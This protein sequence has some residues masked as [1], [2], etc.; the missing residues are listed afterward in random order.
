[1]EKVDLVQEDILQVEVQV[2]NKLQEVNLV[3]LVE[4]EMRQEQVEQE[5]M[6]Q[7]IKVAVVEI[8]EDQA[9]QV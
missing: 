1:M 3:V 5:L 9:V 6:D 8:V 7:L 2:L 4:A